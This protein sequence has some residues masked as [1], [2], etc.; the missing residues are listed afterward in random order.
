MLLALERMVTIIASRP[1]T[2]AQ[3]SLDAL[4]R[5]VAR[6]AK[7]TSYDLRV[8]CRLN[9]LNGW[10]CTRTQNGISEDDSWLI[11]PLGDST[12]DIECAQDVT[13]ETVNCRNTAE[14]ISAMQRYYDFFHAQ[15]PLA[16]GMS[17]LEWSAWLE[18]LREDFTENASDSQWKIADVVG[19]KYAV[20][21]VRRDGAYGAF[22]VLP[23]WKMH[24][25]G[26]NYS[27]KI[28]AEN[29]SS[30][31]HQHAYAYNATEIIQQ[32]E[33]MHPTRPA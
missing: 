32:L 22:L 31:P 1:Q 28:R 25:D 3:A 16:R 14:I 27:Y 24:N 10:T 23:A 13:E 19:A 30:L 15:L 17:P 20:R 6:V 26:T 21:L 11:R 4:R 33:A 8:R 7:Y 9:G 12:Y 18:E 2:E 29:N 5:A